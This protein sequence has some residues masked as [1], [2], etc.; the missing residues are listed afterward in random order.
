MDK[1]EMAKKALTESE[2]APN[3]YIPLLESAFESHRL[4]QGDK[5]IYKPESREYFPTQHIPILWVKDEGPQEATAFKDFSHQPFGV[6]GLTILEPDG[7]LIAPYQFTET[8]DTPDEAMLQTLHS[9]D[10]AALE[11]LRH[12]AKK[13]GKELCVDRHDFC[14]SFL[15]CAM[16]ELEEK[17]MPLGPILINSLDLIWFERNGFRLSYGPNTITGVIATHWGTSIVGCPMIE[18]GEI[19][20]T[21]NMKRGTIA[22]I[23]MGMTLLPTVPEEKWLAFMEVGLGLFRPSE[24]RCIQLRNHND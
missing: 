12:A 13:F 18:R 19:F 20:L 7:Y 2:Q 24:V 23:R 22:P 21:P 4:P 3:R 9:V 11:L 16:V 14:P 1:Y 10:K 6:G 15:N 8:R 5:P 17:W